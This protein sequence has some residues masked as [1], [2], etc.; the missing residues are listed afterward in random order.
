VQNQKVT[1]KALQEGLDKLSTTVFEIIS[2]GKSQW[3]KEGTGPEYGTPAQRLSTNRTMMLNP[4]SRLY[5]GKDNGYMP[6]QY[7]I[8]ADT[9]YVNDYYEDKEGRLVLERLTAD[10]AKN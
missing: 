3:V 4:D 10:Q 5:L 8:G 9:H 7:I 2:R 6:T 1:N